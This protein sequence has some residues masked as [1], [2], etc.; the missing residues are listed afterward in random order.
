[1]KKSHFSPETYDFQVLGST[2]II[3]GYKAIKISTFHKLAVKLWLAE[4]NDLQK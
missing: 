2:L 1:M 4:D 3:A